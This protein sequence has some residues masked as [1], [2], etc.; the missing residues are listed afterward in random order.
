MHLVL[1]VTALQITP[2]LA[3]S[4]VTNVLGKIYT[5]NPVCLPYGCVNPIVPGLMQFGQNVLSM[6]DNKTWN[7]AESHNMWRLT[8]IC[9]RV[10]V[11][12]SFA[13]P[14]GSVDGKPAP[15]ADVAVSQ[16]RQALAAYTAH[17]SALGFDLWEYTEPWTKNECIQ[18][19]WTMACY[20][21]FPRCNTINAGRYLRPCASSCENYLSKCHIQCCDDG[22][23]CVYKH[24]RKMQDG[25]VIVDEGYA[26]HE[27]PSPLCTGGAQS[28]AGWLRLGM[29]ATAITATLLAALL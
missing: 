4:V 21:H 13:L 5:S 15:Q 16:A 19:I 24:A 12:Y 22:L 2:V 1:L 26:P 14:L 3:Q 9:K 6:N 29:S 18:S 7:C 23:Q 25:T 10:V 11:G 27:G 8:G 20:T 17:L 28:P